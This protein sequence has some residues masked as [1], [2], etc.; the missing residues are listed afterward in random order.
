MFPA[1]YQRLK[2][3]YLKDIKTMGVMN[4]T[5]NSFS[6][7]DKLNSLEIIK[8]VFK[9]FSKTFDIIDFGAESTA[10]FNG[11]V[12]S[13]DELERFEKLLFPIVCELIDPHTTISIDTYKPEVFYEVA[14]VLNKFWPNTKI[15]FNDISGK[16]DD[17]LLYLFKDS[18][19]FDYVLCHNLCPSRDLAQDHMRYFCDYI[20]KDVEHFFGE[21][22]KL[23]ELNRKIIADPCFGFSKKHDQNLILLRNLDKISSLEFY[24]SVMIGISRKS[25]LRDGLDL[26]SNLG[27]N[28]AE[29][30]HAIH[31]KDIFENISAPLI[32]R[33]HD[34]APVYSALKSLESL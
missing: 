33:T 12:S 6:D 5:P 10:P 27:I 23:L 32:V 7:A 30:R 18:L 17:E 9:E 15:I 4:L 19:K 28:I 2:S 3:L 16:I 25:F 8:N 20:L 29:Q 34:I 26:K 22:K 21:G 13:R 14:L 31:L 24:D 11:E 1:D